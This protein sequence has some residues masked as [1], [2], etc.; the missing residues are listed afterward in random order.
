MDKDTMELWVQPRLKCKEIEDLQAIINDAFDSIND[1]VLMD[2]NN[3][4]YVDGKS[5]WIRADT[6]NSA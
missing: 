4:Y 6:L 5:F 2:L 3:L 1:N